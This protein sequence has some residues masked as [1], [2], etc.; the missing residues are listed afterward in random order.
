MFM[1]ARMTLEDQG[2]P[3]VRPLLIGVAALMVVAVGLGVA[4][5]D[6]EAITVISASAVSEFPEGI[7]FKAEVQGDN[8]ILQ[9]AVR[10]RIG[11]RTR[12]AYEYMSFEGGTLVDSELFWRTNTGAR[13]IP[14]GTIISYSFEIEDAQGNELA[15]EPA[16]FIYHD[17]RFEWEE[18][19]EGPVTVAYHG[20]VNTRAGIVLDTIIET[21]GHMG[22]LLGADTSI[23]I[24]VTMYNNVKEML[25]AL[26]PGSTTIRR[27]LITEGQAFT[28]LGTLLVLGGGRGAKGTASHEVTHILTHRAAGSVLGGVPSWLGEGLS[29]YGNVDPAFS[30]EIALEF[31]L[32]TKRLLPITSMRGLPGDPEDVIIFYGE[33][34]SIVRFMVAAYGPDKMRELMA[35]MKGG[36]NVNAAILRV[37]GFTSIELENQWRDTIGAPDYLPSQRARVIPTPIPRRDIQLFTLTPQA[38]SQ[39]IGTLEVTATPSPAPTSEPTTEPTTTPEPVATPIPPATATPTPEPV[40]TPIPP[41]TATPEPVARTIS[42]PEPATVPEPDPS[43]V[44]PQR[45]LAPPEGASCN[46]PG[47][48]SA[49]MKDLTMPAFLL[50]LVGLGLRRRRL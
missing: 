23:P 40:A 28:D 12:G 41:A 47:H 6:G 30:Y 7:R 5:A 4:S 46:T 26:P 9:I 36:I 18:V 20:P 37:Y 14:P 11:Q 16:D 35:A 42:T 13:Y 44:E 27:E 43:S 22:P 2:F 29:E 50:G 24:R 8:E 33:A 15:T 31:A 10:I 34:R 1:R 48:F 45:D 3:G 39:T 21:L 19:S 38:G 32:A 25:E 49:G 17:A